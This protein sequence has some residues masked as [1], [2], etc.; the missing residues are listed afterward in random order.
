M[1]DHL[2]PEDAE[3]FEA[4][5]RPL[6]AAASRSCA[7]HWSAADYYSRTVSRSTPRSRAPVRVGSSSRYDD[8]VA[9]LSGP[10]TPGVGWGRLGSA[11]CSAR[12]DDDGLL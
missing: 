7:A 11:I 5:Q 10:D 9:E 2:G 4:V 12:W 6:K 1:I 3:H 8:L